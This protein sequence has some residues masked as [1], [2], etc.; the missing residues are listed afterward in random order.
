VDG[1]SRL[2]DIRD[3]L[4]WS[5]NGRWMN[6]AGLL[7]GD[8]NVSRHFTRPD[9]ENEGVCCKS[10]RTQEDQD[11][12]RKSKN[13][14]VHGEIPFGETIRENLKLASKLRLTVLVQQAFV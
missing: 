7:A 1:K 11:E 14:S 2:G 13:D 6:P 3:E 10:R 12:Q 5:D 9:I 8:A 4:G